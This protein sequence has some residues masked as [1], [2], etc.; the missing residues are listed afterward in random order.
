MGK[1]EELTTDLGDKKA[2]EG[3]K[4]ELNSKIGKL[5]EKNELSED[6]IKNYKKKREYYCCFPT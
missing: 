2:V 3:G 1:R 4:E 6:D 5:K